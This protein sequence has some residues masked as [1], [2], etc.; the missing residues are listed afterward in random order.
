MRVE[1]SATINHPVDGV[2]EYASTPE[3]DPTWVVSSLRHEMLS[4]GPMRVGSITEEDVGFMGWRMRYVWEIT[5]YEPPTD[6]ALRSVSGPLPSTIRLRL[7]PLDG[8]ATRLTLVVEARLRGV[9]GLVAP[10]MKQVAHRQVDTQLRTL[11]DLLE[12]GASEGS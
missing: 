10:L 7:E 1:R 9:Y 4:P 5:R 6:L 8:G 11:K 3:N 2:F 12:N